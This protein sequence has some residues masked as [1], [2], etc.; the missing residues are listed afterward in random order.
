MHKLCCFE[1]WHI[2]E[3]AGDLIREDRLAMPVVRSASKCA[4][5]ALDV[6]DFVSRLKQVRYAFVV[7]H[8]VNFFIHLLGGQH[9]T[10]LNVWLNLSVSLLQ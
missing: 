6:L 7:S 3:S 10:L 2:K 1:L 5:G 4:Y 8:D 9:D